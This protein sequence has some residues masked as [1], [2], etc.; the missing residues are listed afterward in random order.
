MGSVGDLELALSRI[1]EAAK[2]AD[3][4]TR[5]NLI[6]QLRKT[7]VSLE[8]SGETI[9]RLIYLAIQPALC[10]AGNDLD[11]FKILADNDG[12]MTT[13]ELAEKTK[14][15]P[16]LLSRI[17]RFLASTDIVTEVGEETFIADNITKALAKPGL[18]AG[19]NHTS[20]IVRMVPAKSRETRL[21][22]GVMTAQ[23]EGMDVWLDLFPFEEYVKDLDPAQV[24]F[25]D[26]GGGIGHKCLELKTRFP[27]LKGEVILEDLPITLKH[28]LSIDGV[29]ALPQ[30]FFTPQQ[31]KNAR[32]Y[33][34]RNIL[35]DWPDDKCKIILD[36]LREAMG[37]NSAILID[38]IVLP[39]SGTNF[40]AMNID[41]T[42]MAALSAMERT[43]SQW[44]KVLRLSW[45]QGI[46]DLYL[47]RV[48]KR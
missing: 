44:E 39:N 3:E 25:V 5:K 37:P 41:F 47:Y 31:I 11:L 45:S 6:N 30:D 9:Q 32:F 24:M 28:A 43:Q 15:D 42:M 12:P 20:P 38:E 23:R 8:T 34:M 33:Y 1:T 19:M 16:L 10:R 40:Q 7:A 14:C 46:E 2:V 18:K 26:V 48:F 4:N 27:A 36:H 35:H 13:T 17:L 21:L 22:H 29:K